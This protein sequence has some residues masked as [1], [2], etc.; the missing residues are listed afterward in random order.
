MASFVKKKP[1]TDISEIL[2]NK[3]M[4]PKEKEEKSILSKVLI[5]ELEKRKENIKNIL[6]NNIKDS[7]QTIL[8]ENIENSRQIL[9]A[10]KLKISAA[11]NSSFKRSSYYKLNNFYINN[12][13]QGFSI[14]F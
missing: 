14:I 8:E 2:Q 1:I 9:Y 11:L 10:K 13:I 6:E 4:Y 5:K 12:L 3:Y 7:I